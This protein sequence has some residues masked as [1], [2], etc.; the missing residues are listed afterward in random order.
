MPKAGGSM[1]G[2]LD[3]NGNKITNLPSPTSNSEPATKEY[4]DGNALKSDIF[5]QNSFSSIGHNGVALGFNMGNLLSFMQNHDLV[6]IEIIGASSK[7][8]HL[9]FL[10]FEDIDNLRQGLYIELDLQEATNKNYYY[11]LY[12]SYSSSEY[13]TALYILTKTSYI[14]TNWDYEFHL[15]PSASLNVTNVNFKIK[16]VKL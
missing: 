2:I 12:L 7:G 4:V 3:M 1:G 16:G 11:K 15:I 13:Y 6:Y 14:E 9:F 8:G 10:P 5:Y